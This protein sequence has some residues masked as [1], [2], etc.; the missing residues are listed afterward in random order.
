MIKIEKGIKL[1]KAKAGRAEKYPV[2]DMEVGDSI[3][4]ETQ[5]DECVRKL[6]RKMSAIFITRLKSKKVKMKF[7]TRI[8][9]KPS[10]VRIFRVQ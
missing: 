7:A 3:F 9:L 4:V 2:F 5:K 10:G 8:E 1:P 6:Q